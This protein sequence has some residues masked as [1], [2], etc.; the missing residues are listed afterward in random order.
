MTAVLITFGTSAGVLVLL[1]ALYLFE[2]ARGER[3]LLSGFRHLIDRLFSFVYGLIGS[4][5]GFLWRGIV[6]LVLHYGVHKLLGAVM[7]FLHKLQMRVEH[8]VVRHHHETSREGKERN[9]L[10][11]IAEHKEASALSE[12]EKQQ[13]RND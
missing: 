1:S 10:D 5:L 6:T 2:D 8:V 3:V 9:H 12:E 7:A 4:F 11:E 13:R